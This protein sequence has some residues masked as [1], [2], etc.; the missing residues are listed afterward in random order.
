M[1]S[2]IAAAL[3]ATAVMAS[4]LGAPGPAFAQAQDPFIFVLPTRHGGS[5]DG[6]G[7]AWW[8]KDA[9]I[10]PQGQAV[11]GVSMAALNDHRGDMA[12]NRWC[13]A[14]PLSRNSFA[15]SDRAIQADIDESMSD[16][17]TANF[18]VS[19]AFTGGEPLDAVVGNYQSCDGAV[20]AFLLITDRSAERRIVFLEEWENWKGLIWLR[21]QDD[22]LVVGSCFECGHADSLFHDFRRGR[23]YWDSTG[24]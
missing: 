7:V 21:H 6:A 14:S 17:A 10:R 20:G 18:A 11:S 4:A 24:D 9:S 3:T 2:L 15:S 19:G 16:P 8:L 12:P 13:F 23:F 1:K 22:A 5:R